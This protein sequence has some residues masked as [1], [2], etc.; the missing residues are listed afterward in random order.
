MKRLLKRRVYSPEIIDNLKNINKKFNERSKKYIKE[1]SKKIDLEKF[2]RFRRKAFAE[3]NSKHHSSVVDGEKRNSIDGSTS[4]ET[5][6]VVSYIHMEENSNTEEEYDESEA[7]QG[8]REILTNVFSDD[9]FKIHKGYFHDYLEKFKKLQSY[10]PTGVF[11]PANGSDSYDAYEMKPEELHEF[12]LKDNFKGIITHDKFFEFAKREFDDQVA[13]RTERKG[14][15]FEN[16]KE[17][18][19]SLLSQ[20]L[21]IE[22][23][24]TITYESKNEDEFGTTSGVPIIKVEK[25]CVE[26]FSAQNF[27]GLKPLVLILALCK[28]NEKFRVRNMDGS[29]G[30]TSPDIFE[31]KTH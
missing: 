10:F 12:F 22:L 30:S 31:I 15:F 19:Y 20:Y 14:G 17:E 4:E 1:N 21:K 3:K 9:L 5:V 23:R 28:L 18:S 7:M 8:M 16:E 11:I 27:E 26:H 6:N 24:V 25:L 29:V 2:N 13:K